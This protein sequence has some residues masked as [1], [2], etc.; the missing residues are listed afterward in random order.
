MGASRPLLFGG[1][2]IT[3][4]F[5]RRLDVAAGGW[6]AATVPVMVIGDEELLA[7]RSAGAY[8]AAIWLIR[9]ADVIAIPGL[10]LTVVGVVPQSWWFPYLLVLLAAML[11]LALFL[12]ARAGVRA[13]GGRVDNKVARTIL[14]DLVMMW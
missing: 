12:F 9:I 11:V 8:W 7:V 5:A 3:A 6:S 2:R 14:R 4:G 13:E 10:I 1:L